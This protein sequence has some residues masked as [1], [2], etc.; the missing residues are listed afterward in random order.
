MKL[1]KL[2]LLWMWLTTLLLLAGCGYRLVGSSSLPAHIKKI[3]IPKFVNKT[4]EP[5]IEDVL[6]Q[7]MRTV[8]NRRG[9]VK[10]VGKETAD[11]LLSGIIFSYND[12]E[13]IDFN[14]QNNPSQY[15][16]TITVD[17][18]LQD[19][20]TDRILWK[21]QQLQRTADFDGGEDYDLSEETENKRTALE[22]LANDLAQEVLTLS[23]ESF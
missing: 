9:K 21:E 13:A 4:Q 18:E 6:T 14:D 20:T 23:T 2:S 17:I 22:N 5:E 12:D 15:R 7:A 11:A 10:L 3:A 8:F 19:L 1:K 16:L